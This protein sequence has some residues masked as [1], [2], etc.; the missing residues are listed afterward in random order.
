MKFAAVIEYC[1][2]K[3]KILEVRPAHREYLTGVVKSGRLVVGGPYI[4]DSGAIII[5][6]AESVEEAEKLL[7]DDPF[8]KQGVFVSWTIRPWKVVM[9]NT[10]LVKP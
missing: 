1:P 6:E 8:A 10:D 2:D 5:Y 7:R 9:S 3:A 4:D